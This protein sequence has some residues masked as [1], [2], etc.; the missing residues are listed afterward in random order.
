[1]RLWNWRRTWLWLS[2]ISLVAL[3]AGCVTIYQEP[4]AQTL[5][6]AEGTPPAAG[7]TPAAPVI[8]SFTAS[9]GT[10]IAGQPVTLSWN[11]SGA[12][13]VDISPFVG[14]VDATGTVL[15]TPAVTTTYTLTAG[16]GGA[17]VSGSVTVTVAPTAP[18]RPDLVITEVWLTGSTINYKIKNQGDAA[19]RPSRSYLYVNDLEQSNSY[20]ES[21]APGEEKTE[22]FSNYQWLFS[23]HQDV[24]AGESMTY[25]IK[26]CADA[27][28]SVDEAGED[29]N[30]R[31]LVLGDKFT[32]DFMEKAHLAEWR[33]GAGQLTWPMVAGDTRGSAFISRDVLEDGKSYTG[34]GLYPQ[35][36]T[37]GAIQGMFGDF[38]SW[39]GE[40]RS[41]DIVMPAGARFTAKVGFKEGATGSDGARAILAVVDASGKTIYLREK[42]V[43]Y[44][45]KL[46]A[47]DIDLSS[48]V[49][50]KGFL[51]L[52]VEA[53]GSAGQDWLVW[54]EPTFFQE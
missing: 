8:N 36:V 7:P 16:S 17:A 33:S 24:I 52:R 29:N 4:P 49:G 26:V 28:E 23:V 50:Q 51:V 35:Q 27:E 2:V 54:A 40:T 15:V 41:R 44:D 48:L 43:Y 10:V 38:Y 1:M 21:V 31:M 25:A 20:V 46:D 12:A 42:D 11:V 39:L 18:G 47:F 6:P 14:A 32:Y 19:A 22:Y 13:G 5:P 53:R 34:L 45:G 9:P 37:D 3:A 30:C